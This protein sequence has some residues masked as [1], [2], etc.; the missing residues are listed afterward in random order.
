MSPLSN[1][2]LTCQQ[3]EQMEPFYPLHVRICE[4]CFLVQ[5]TEFESPEQIFRDYAYF[6]SCSESWLQHARSYVG[7][8]QE[9]LSLSG[10]SLVVELAS[11]DG[12]LLQ[13]FQAMQIPVLGVEPAANVAS[14]AGRKVSRLSRNSSAA[15]RLGGSPRR[16]KEL[17]SSW[18]IMCSPMSL[19]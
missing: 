2:Y 19:T 11:N 12:Y 13:F 18:R 9:R 10:D 5:L 6:S 3:L 1:A 15:K 7:Q 14:A 17:T 8:M 16:A 4:E